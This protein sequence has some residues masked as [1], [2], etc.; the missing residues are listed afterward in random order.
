MMS[1][2]NTHHIPAFYHAFGSLYLVIS[3]LIVVYMILGFLCILD[4]KGGIWRL[5]GD[6]KKDILGPNLNVPTLK[7]YDV[8]PFISQCRDVVTSQCR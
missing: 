4:E 5:C 6:M 8:Q 3:V 7:S 2:Q 1:A